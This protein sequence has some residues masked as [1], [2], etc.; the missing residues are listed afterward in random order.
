MENNQTDLT[1]EAEVNTQAATAVTNDFVSLEFILGKES[2]ELTSLAQDVI[3]VEKLGKVPVTALDNPEYKRIKKD[4]MSMV[5]DG[6]SGRMRPELDDDKL[7]AEV[8]VEAVHKDTRSNFTFRSKELL[9]KLG[10][11]TATQALEK[12]VSPGEIFKAAMIVQD[13]SGFGDKAEEETVKEVKNS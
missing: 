7:M 2:Q 5:K 3:E 12:L 11:L 4:C 13:I 1:K 10:V 6:K 8:I 9:A